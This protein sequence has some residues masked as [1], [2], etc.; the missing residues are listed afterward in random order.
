[1]IEGTLAMRI[2]L[3]FIAVTGI[4]GAFVVLAPGVVLSGWYR[5]DAATVSRSICG[6]TASDRT[7]I[8]LPFTPGASLA[9]T[10]PGS[11]RYRPGDKT[12][13]VVT[14]DPALLDHVHIENDTLSLDCD[15]VG[16]SPELEIDLTGPA[17]TDWKLLGSANLTLTDISQRQLQLNIKGSGNVIVAGAV[18]AV[19]LKISG[20]GKAQL[21]SLVAKS[22]EIEIR[23]SGGTQLT[24]ETSADVSIYG[25][26]NVE[27]FGHANLGRSEVRGS[28]RIIKVP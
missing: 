5:A 3:I 22:A 16:R 19:E 2:T 12:E 9:I 1:M 26:G 7:Q 28:G 15:L 10:L 21:K 27:L 14:G 18:E 6:S 8:T 25:S 4:F 13:A 11:V 23:G 17:I 24:A 20:S